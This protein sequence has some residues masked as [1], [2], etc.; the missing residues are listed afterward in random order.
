MAAITGTVIAAGA[1]A[2]SANQAKKGA[3][4]A[5]NSTAAA[6]G[7]ARAAN[8]ANMQPWLN[9]GTGALA[10]MQQLNSGNF[11][12]FKESPDYQ[13]TLEQ[14]LQGLDRSAAARGGLYSGGQQADVLNYATGLASQQYGNFY[15]R[16][17]SEE[18]RVRK[19][20]RSG[21]S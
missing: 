4:G 12:S 3:Q 11:S 19:E 7:E 17:R 6:Q 21:W 2:Y 20:C 15:N 18:R 8:Q 13:F 5:A 10:Q 14:G 16:L 9:A 1:T